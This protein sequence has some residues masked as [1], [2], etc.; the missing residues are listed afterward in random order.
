MLTDSYTDYTTTLRTVII[1]GVEFNYKDGNSIL[2]WV[3]DSK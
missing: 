3:Q 1:G 2:I